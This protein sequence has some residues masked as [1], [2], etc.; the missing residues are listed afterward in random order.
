M[1]ETQTSAAFIRALRAGD[2][3][4]V[5]RIPKSDLHSHW[6]YGARIEAFEK[7]AG[8]PIP[9]PP[10]RMSTV[11]EMVTWARK[12]LWAVF[13]THLEHHKFALR[14][15]FEQ[16][17]KD[18]ITLLEMSVDA[19]ICAETFGGDEQKLVRSLSETHKRVAPRIRFVPELSIKGEAFVPVD[20]L[21]RCFATGYFGSLDL[22]AVED[23]GGSY[24]DYARIY[25]RAKKA[26][27]KLKAHVGEFGTAALV[28]KAVETLELDAVQ[29]GISA[30][31]S[32]SV[33][34]W[35]AK[36]RIQ[37]N[38][39]PTS[40]VML[41]RVDRMKNHPI[42]TL[43]EYGV[44]VTVNTDDL[45]IF[46]QSVSDEYLNLYKA[47]VLSAEQ[48]DSVRRTGLSNY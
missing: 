10:A 11:K 2:A 23:T 5:A 48:L 42:R 44:P 27:L 22:Y 17:K 33:M 43:F 37:L 3:K 21:N 15:S 47:R 36:K 40:N 39:C 1:N 28:K 14:A 31:R 13:P 16:A 9:R 6:L 35:L 41:K 24:G 26:G 45:A 32:P 38:V 12:R 4:A 30:A 34:R 46:G 29:H 8:H 19:G 7:Y 20:F 18:G 25:R